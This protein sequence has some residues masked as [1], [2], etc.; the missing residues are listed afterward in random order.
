MESIDPLRESKAW[1]DSTN[2]NLRSPQ[3]AIRARGKD[4]EEVLRE[5]QEFR[6]W[7]KEM[8]IE[9]TDVSKAMANNPAAVE[10]QKDEKV[11]KFRRTT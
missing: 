9:P 10:K 8:G 4:P 5:I 3:E 11:V 6:E 1:V 7:E 2:A